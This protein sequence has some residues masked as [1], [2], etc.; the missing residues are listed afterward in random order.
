MDTY[1][2][3]ANQAF[4]PIL[5]ATG[6]IIWSVVS[7]ALLLFLLGKFAFP[8]VK[9]IMAERTAKIRNDIEGA[10][11]ARLE[12]ER[13]LAEYRTQLEEA[14]KEANRLVEEARKT[15][16]LVREELL[17]KAHEEAAEIKRRAE[18]S[19]QIEKERAMSELRASV[20]D[21]A[22]ELASRIIAYEV[23]RR[24]VDPLVEQ[25]LAESGVG[26]K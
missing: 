20:G 18:E 8:P 13:V 19:L 7:F 4:N 25:F 23:D 15:A 1:I 3:G 24:S 2:F 6:E 11:K 22:V 10:E 5:P 9:K 14:R 16:G 21:L 12:A 26:S 17:A